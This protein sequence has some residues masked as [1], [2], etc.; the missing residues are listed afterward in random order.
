MH[1]CWCFRT[2]R[3][4]EITNQTAKKA[5]CN[6][7]L[8]SAGRLA[9]FLNRELPNNR[10]QPTTSWVIVKSREP[11]ATVMTTSNIFTLGC[12]GS[13]ITTKKSLTRTGTSKIPPLQW[14]SPELWDTLS[15]TMKQF[16]RS[17][18]KVRY[19]WIAHPTFFN[20]YFHH[21]NTST[22]VRTMNISGGFARNK[23]LFQ[24]GSAEWQKQAMSITP[25]W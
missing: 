1:R 10:K 24:S 16:H 8:L 6:H 2:F 4:R 14:H 23:V 3:W 19:D 9:V 18:Q 25:I 21:M 12:H 7:V 17:G 5:G 11:P 22:L 20:N 15:R 13:V